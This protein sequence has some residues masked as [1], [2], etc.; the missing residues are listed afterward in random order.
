ML[1]IIAFSVALVISAVFVGVF[2]KWARTRILDIPGHRSSH[3]IPT[4]RGGGLA[5]VVIVLSGIWVAPIPHDRALVYTIAG[6]LVAAISL[7]DDIKG[8]RW[9]V[10]MATHA[11]CAA[12]LIWHSD[13]ISLATYRIGGLD[14]GRALA[15][16]IAFLWIVG[17]TNAYNFMDGIDGIAAGQGI[18][19]AFAWWAM[20]AGADSFIATTAALV[21]G[22]TAGFLIHN[23]HPAK[24]FMG[25]VGS[26]FLGLTFAGF[27]L[28]SNGDGRRMAI[29]A[30]LIVLPFIVDAFFTFLRRAS[31]GEHVFTAHRSHWYQRLVIT[32]MSHSSTALLYSAVAAVTGLAAV[33]LSRGLW[34]A[35]IALV[36]AALAAMAGVYERVRR[37][38]N[39]ASSNAVIFS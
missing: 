14:A 37:R 13:L 19:A 24:I 5:I 17:L 4:P 6:A 18:V 23:R 10:R 8:I 7:A 29:A 33:A 27:P 12:L 21:A 39:A 25:D 34:K 20:M 35:A 9:P 11:A 3:S 36:V 26:A 16:A 15:T 38:E 2:Q 28:L 30:P 1:A 22:S 31:R 32:G